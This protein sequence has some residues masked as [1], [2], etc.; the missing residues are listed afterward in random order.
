MSDNFT[1]LDTYYVF[2]KS[3]LDRMRYAAQYSVLLGGNYGDVTQD[4]YLG[5][6]ILFNHDSKSLAVTTLLNNPWKEPELFGFTPAGK[7]T[8]VKS[9]DDTS[10]LQTTVSS[11]RTRSY[12][13]FYDSERKE[14]IA[15][16]W[17]NVDPDSTSYLPCTG[18]GSGISDCGLSSQTTVFVKGFDGNASVS[19]N[20]GLALY[21]ANKLLLL[22]IDPNGRIEKYP[23][24]ELELD[25]K[26]ASNL[27]GIK[28]VSNGA[29]IGYLGMKFSGN[30]IESVSSSELD[31]ALR[32][33][34]NS[35]VMEKLSN[36]YVSRKTYLGISS[37]G[38]EGIMFAF[39]D[40]SAGEFG[41]LD[42]AYMAKSGPAGL[43]EYPKKA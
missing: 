32:D 35:I 11:D 2:N 5:G 38:S 20:K 15:R 40:P 13:S 18:S 25:D 23:G 29:Q 30:S 43:E 8:Y 1:T 42:P 34:K 4:G 33:R 6:E 7:Y 19:E 37:R 36:R 21:S 41:A 10:A 27:L 22:R 16:A 28:I 9:T 24:V 14:Y 31:T 26:T 3:K 39:Q 17:L 12:I